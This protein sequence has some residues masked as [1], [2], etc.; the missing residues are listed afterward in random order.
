MR[1]LFF[2]IPAAW[3]LL[4][5]ACYKDKGNYTYDFPAEPV[6]SGLDT[7]YTVWVGDSL[8]IEPKVSIG[9]SAPNLNYQWKISIPEEFRDTSFSGPALKLAFGLGP[10]R[11]SAQLTITDNSNGMK[12]FYPF[13]IQGKTDFST[14]IAVL[15]LENGKSQ[16]SFI[17]PDGTVQ[18]RIYSAMHGEDLPGGPKQIVAIWMRY[19]SPIATRSYWINCT[20]GIDPAVQI[21]PNTMKRKKTIR[22]NFFDAPAAARTGYFENTDNGVLRGVINGKLYEGAWQTF[23][24]SD[25]YGMFGQPAQGDYELY[26]RAVFNTAPYYLGYEKN[27]KQIVAFTNFGGPAYIGTSYS[28]TDANAFDP[29]NMGVDAV[30]FEQINFN[31]C[32]LFGKDASGTV[33]EFMF[34]PRFIG[35]VQVQPQYKRAFPQQALITATTKWAGSPFEVFYF[36]SGDKIY[37]YNPTNQEIKPLITDFGGKNV[38]MVKVIDN[39]NTLVAGTEGTLYYLDISTGKF[40]EVIKKYEGIP[41]APVDAHNRTF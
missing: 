19:I 4:L 24:G 37:R 1:K 40:G 17:K 10:N 7:L 3:L 5:T 41:G 34:T 29:A 28:L 36:T 20:D 32:Y 33:Y 16:L 13:A 12:Y 21:D 23:Y 18:P 2:I 27:R 11:Y 22:Q 6:V 39:G 26:D 9:N 35:F 8:K 31:N 14:G 15:S 25:V 30:H 38:S